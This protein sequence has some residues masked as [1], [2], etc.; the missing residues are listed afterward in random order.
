VGLLLNTG[1]AYADTDKAEA[2][3]KDMYCV[4]DY[5][6]KFDDG[7][8]DPKKLAETIV[9]LC[10]DLHEKSEQAV[11]PEQ[12]AATPADKQRDVEFMHT[13]AAVLWSQ[14]NLKGRQ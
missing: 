3:R 2:A 1:I 7:T 5:V 8:K 10:H 12:W 14:Q 9:P 4:R 11:S 6:A 13:W